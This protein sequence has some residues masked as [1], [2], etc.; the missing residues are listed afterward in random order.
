VAFG[1]VL[2]A[3]TAVAELAVD[4]VPLFTGFKPKDEPDYALYSVYMGR[5]RKCLDSPDVEDPAT[6][7]GAQL[8]RMVL[9]FRAYMACLVRVFTTCAQSRVE[10]QRPWPRPTFAWMSTTMGMPHCCMESR[11]RGQ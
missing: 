9:A 8:L 11:L 1:A 3:V 4:T 2:L 7:A 10:Q 6:E 5:V